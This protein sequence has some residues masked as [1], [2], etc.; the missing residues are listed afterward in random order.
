MWGWHGLVV[1]FRFRVVLA[2]LGVV[3]LGVCLGGWRTGLLRTVRG[4]G[5][6]RFVRRRPI[7]PAR[8]GVRRRIRA[9]PRLAD[10]PRRGV[11]RR[12]RAR[13]RL[14]DLPRR[15]VRRPIRIVGSGL[16]LT[17]SGGRN[18]RLAVVGGLSAQRQSCRRSA[19]SRGRAGRRSRR[20]SSN[21]ST[22]PGRD[23]HTGRQHQRPVVSWPVQAP[24]RLLVSLAVTRRRRQ[25]GSRYRQ[26]PPAWFA[27]RSHPPARRP[28]WRYAEGTTERVS[29]VFRRCG[30]AAAAP[31]TTMTRPAATAARLKASIRV[32]TRCP[33]VCRRA[34]RRHHRGDGFGSHRGVRRPVVAG[35]GLR[36]VR[37]ALV[38]RALRDQSI[39]SCQLFID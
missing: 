3:V 26:A 28:T 23:R 15:G 38:G 12:I 4:V 35:A 10:L 11:R 25:H 22:H 2:R 17:G 18:G 36:A 13:P 19:R 6:G 5:S 20:E 31:A 37:R 7:E 24:W 9:R 29:V 8:S 34:E 27:A 14:A 1:L 30:A 32:P 39:S 16:S 33:I 21:W